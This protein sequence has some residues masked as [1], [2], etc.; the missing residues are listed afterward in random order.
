M[1]DLA[2]LGVKPPPVTDDAHFGPWFAEVAGH[3][4]NGIDLLICG[5]PYRVAEVEAYYF[6]EAHPD[7]FAHRDPIQLRIGRWY[8]HRTG[9]TYRGGSFKGVDLTFGDGRATFG[10]LV[11][12]IVTPHGM[13]IDGPSLI[14]D[15]LL[16]RLNLKTVAQ[17]DARIA[18]RPV[19]DTTSPVAVRAAETPRMA[20]VYATGRV[21][22]T[23]KRM[24]AKPDGPRFVMRP[25]RYLTEPRRIE[26]GRPQLV[27]ALHQQ[28][29]DTSAIHALTGVPK[30][31]IARYVADFTTGQALPDFAGYIGKDLGTAD[32]C[33]LIGTWAAKQGPIVPT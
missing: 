32:L 3:L 1:L 30:K 13:P 4:L 27:L 26:K 19:W 10:M 24:H 20:S 12:T 7:P 18:G 15:H 5:D 33:K 31:T 16:A 14:V 23:L 9:G 21:G 29:R 11:R 8:F 28:E 17:L 22:L 25:Y 2:A 6:S